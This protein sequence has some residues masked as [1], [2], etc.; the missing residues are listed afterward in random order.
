MKILMISG[1]LS[2]KRSG[3]L[4]AYVEDLIE[5]LISIGHEIVYLDMNATSLSPFVH[6]IKEQNK[7]NEYTLF[8]SGVVIDGMD[9]TSEPLKQVYPSKRLEALIRKVLQFEKPDVIHIHELLGFPVALLKSL[10]QDNYKIIFTAQDYYT[11]C[12]TIKLFRHDKKICTL[13]SEELI[14]KAC[15]SESKF[16]A[17]ISANNIVWRLA[18]LTRRGGRLWGIASHRIRVLSRGGHRY[19]TSPGN[20]IT[21]RHKF[22]EYIAFIDVII[23]MS[24]LHLKVMK[25]VIGDQKNLQHMYLSRKTFAIT[26]IKKPTVKRENEKVIFVALNINMP[27]K[28][29][30]LLHS[31]FSKIEDKY[32]NFELRIYSAEGKDSKCIRYMGFYTEEQ[33]DDIVLAADFGIVPSLWQEAYGYV[34]AEMLSRGLPL[35]VS[36]KG[37][38]VEYIEDGVNGFVFDPDREGSLYSVVE[39]IITDPELRTKILNSTLNSCSNFQEFS[40]HVLDLERLYNEV[41]IR[42]DTNII[43]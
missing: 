39:Q 2:P 26:P 9:G 18:K 1:G 21:R 4:V 19:F 17:E 8:N 31:V 10:K 34:G 38:M 25:S 11:L 40:K 14:C 3:G 7:Y 16:S 15:C 13:S 29:S 20:Y 24:K 43:T 23:C 30:E 42:Y 37:A 36:S 12:P 41:L 35:I 28:G 22:I 6:V 27:A 33:L 5:G 32:D